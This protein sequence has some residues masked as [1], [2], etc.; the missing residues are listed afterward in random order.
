VFQDKEDLKAMRDLLVLLVNEDFQEALL[1][2][3]HQMHEVNG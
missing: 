2:L 3:P 1:P